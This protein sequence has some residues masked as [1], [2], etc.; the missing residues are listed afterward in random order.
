[1]NPRLSVP[2]AEEVVDEF[3][4]GMFNKCQVSLNQI[5]VGLE[6][7]AAERCSHSD[8]YPPDRIVGIKAKPAP[9]L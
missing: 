3:N 6:D 8:N 7:I 5:A 4:L 9:L 2:A 1:V